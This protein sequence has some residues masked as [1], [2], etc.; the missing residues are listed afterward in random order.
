MQA[1]VNSV[2]LEGLHFI[3]ILAVLISEPSSTRI[4]NKH[5]TYLSHL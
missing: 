5:N 2:L 4:Q 3:G 1:V